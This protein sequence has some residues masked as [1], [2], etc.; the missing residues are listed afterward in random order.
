MPKIYARIV[1]DAPREEVWEI[2]GNFTCVAAY[3]P[4]VRSA[5]V[6]SDT[7]SGPGATRRL[8]LNSRGYVEESVTSWSEGQGFS[9]SVIG[10]PNTL[11]QRSRRWWLAQQ[12]NSTEVTLEVDYRL[13]YGPIG[14]LR[15]LV[16][17]RRALRG[18]SHRSLSGLKY[19]VETGEAVGDSV[20]ELPLAA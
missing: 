7:G 9:V 13:K 14:A 1:I 17:T 12:G 2:L 4:D 16:S 15:D 11:K 10:P 19:H 3:S 20:P 6:V 18:T 8:E 5:R